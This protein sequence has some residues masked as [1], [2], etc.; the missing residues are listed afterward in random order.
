M[1]PKESKRW[2]I[3]GRLLRQVISVPRRKLKLKA[4]CKV[5]FPE[6]L[7][8]GYAVTESGIII[9]NVSVDKIE[10][11]MQQFIVMHDVPLYF[12]LEVPANQDDETE[13]APGI[14]NVLHKD[15]Y[16][17]DGCSQVEAITVMLRVGKIL[18]NDGLS[19]FGYGCHDSVN[20]IMFGKYNILQINSKDL[21]P[22]EKMLKEH[23]IDQDDDFITAWDTFTDDCPGVSEAYKYKGKTVYDIPKQFKEWGM[24]LAEQREE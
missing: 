20:E 13:V 24:Y 4:G 2:K 11:I 22:Y 14:V 10:E 16:Y 1:R 5:P 12:F 6:K 23:G 18:F 8:E 17:M 7:Y 9:A 21:A 3:V 19:S 15:V